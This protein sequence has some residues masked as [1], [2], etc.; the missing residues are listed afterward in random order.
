MRLAIILFTSPV[1][2]ATA[3]YSFLYSSNSILV[4]ISSASRVAIL[5]NGEDD[6]KGLCYI[7]IILFLN[8]TFSL[9]WSLDLE[10]VSIERSSDRVFAFH[11]DTIGVTRF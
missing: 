3:G 7:Q 6:N 11:Q 10:L 5:A 4:V 9:L 1:L 2:V 8:L